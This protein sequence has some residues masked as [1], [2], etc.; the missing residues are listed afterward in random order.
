MKHL[1]TEEIYKIAEKYNQ[2]TASL[3]DGEIYI[4]RNGREL[5]EF[6]KTAVNSPIIG[7]AKEIGEKFGHLLPGTNWES[8]ADHAPE[9]VFVW[10]FDS[11]TPRYSVT[12]RNNIVIVP[13]GTI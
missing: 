11:S 5:R 9:E 8:V 4:S 3:K 2:K 12:K 1:T 10:A 7:T 6:A 13:I